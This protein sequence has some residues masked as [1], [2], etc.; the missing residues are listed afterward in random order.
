MKYT[1]LLLLISVQFLSAQDASTEDLGKTINLSDYSTNNSSSNSNM[2]MQE[3]INGDTFMYVTAGSMTGNLNPL[4]Q[5]FRMYLMKEYGIGYKFYGCS[6]M[7]PEL[8]FM[9]IM[10]A[11]IKEAYGEDFISNERSKAQILFEKQS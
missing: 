9:N 1:I 6:V 5:F 10:N 8:A 7:G 3:M 4:E 2:T 11:R